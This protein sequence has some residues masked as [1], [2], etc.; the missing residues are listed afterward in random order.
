MANGAISWC[1]RAKSGSHIC[2]SHHS[3]PHPLKPISIF[4]LLV[5]LQIVGRGQVDVESLFTHVSLITK[6]SCDDVVAPFFFCQVSSITQQPLIS[7]S[8]LKASHESFRPLRPNNSPSPENFSTLH[9]H[10]CPHLGIGG[11]HGDVSPQ[12]ALHQIPH[13][14]LMMHKKFAGSSS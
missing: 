14:G 2:H 9:V 4:F 5:G 7:E 10:V 13:D 6:G 12:S 1:N 11:R 3:L 8:M